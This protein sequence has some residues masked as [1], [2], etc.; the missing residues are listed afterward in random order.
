MNLDVM[1]AASRPKVGFLIDHSNTCDISSI[2][3]ILRSNPDKVIQ[4]LA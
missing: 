1:S 3:E 4:V 2:Y